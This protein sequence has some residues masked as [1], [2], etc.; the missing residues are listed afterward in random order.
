MKVLN[1]DHVALSVKDLDCSCRF[2]ERVLGLEKIPRPDFNFPGAWYRLGEVQ[3]LHLLQ[4][5]NV[6]GI[7]RTSRDRHFALRVESVKD[8]AKHLD[9]LEIAYR[10]PKQRPDGVWQVFLRDPD[11]SVI[12]LFS[13]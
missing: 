7:P 3:E 11:Q 13:S 2:Y 6:E 5:D 12:E 10:G 9:G 4:R 8:A 1:L